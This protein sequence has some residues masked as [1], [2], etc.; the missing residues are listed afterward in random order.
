MTEN[1]DIDMDESE[2]QWAQQMRTLVDDWRESWPTISVPSCAALAI[3]SESRLAL[4][5]DILADVCIHQLSSPLNGLF[6][7]AIASH[8]LAPGDA[9]TSILSLAGFK[10]ALELKCRR[11]LLTSS[12]MKPLSFIAELA[13]ERLIGDVVLVQRSFDRLLAALAKEKEQ[14]PAKA[15]V[16][17]AYPIKSESR[18]LLPRLV[19][20]LVGLDPRADC[21]QRCAAYL[22]QIT[23][24]DLFSHE[25]ALRA[26][27]A[28]TLPLAAAEATAR[29][30]Q[31]RRDELRRQREKRRELWLAKYR[32]RHDKL[33]RQRDDLFR[34]EREQR[35]AQRRAELEALQRAWHVEHEEW[36]CQNE[37]WFRCERRRQRAERRDEI[38]RQLY[39]LREMR[40]TER[41]ASAEPSSHDD[42]DQEEDR[43]REEE[44]NTLDM[45]LN[46]ELDD[47]LD[48]LIVVTGD[49]ERARQ[50]RLLVFLLN[51]YHRES[52][53][54]TDEERRRRQQADRMVDEM[55]RCYERMSH[56]WR[57]EDADAIVDE[58]EGANSRPQPE[59][60]FYHRIACRIDGLVASEVHEVRGPH[61]A[62]R[63]DEWLQE[64]R[65]LRSDNEVFVRVQRELWAREQRRSHLEQMRHIRHYERACQVPMPTERSVL[66]ELL[67]QRRRILTEKRI[68]PY[69]QLHR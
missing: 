51:V 52:R 30:K 48:D 39:Q 16:H 4:F 23:E 18:H 46:H 9:D 11:L 56:L 42:A 55:H 19:A 57:Q 21:E 10:A 5:V 17:D 29:K 36:K 67:D 50:L 60:V 69:R 66:D 61:A 38:E 54:K 33:R 34:R 3:E 68:G 26:E 59:T 47:E 65:R 58:A 7:S 45:Q 63:N 6:C 53:W 1:I 27:L 37:N 8:I 64:E 49:V 15:C 44:E 2:A 24:S 14:P 32:E 41:Q 22:R 43:E 31:L 35:T 28:S 12:T 62:E 25:P 20:A 40:S 13:N